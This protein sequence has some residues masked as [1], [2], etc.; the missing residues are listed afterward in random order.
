M[1]LELDCIHPLPLPDRFTF[2][3]YLDEYHL[4]KKQTNLKSQIHCNVGN[5]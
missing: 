3:T 2:M 4:F 1:F 5:W